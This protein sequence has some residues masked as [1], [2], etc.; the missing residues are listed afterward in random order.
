MSI[1]KLP[2]EI[3][4]QIFTLL[5]KSDQYEC[6][7][8][9]KSCSA[10]A[11]EAFYKKVTLPFHHLGLLK[12]AL[13]QPNVDHLFQHDKWVKRVEFCV[14]DCDDHYPTN[15]EEWFTTNDL[16][17]LFRHLPN[18]KSI[19]YDQ[20]EERCNVLSDFLGSISNIDFHYLAKIEEVS[21]K[22][23]K[24]RCN[25]RH[26]LTHLDVIFT[27][28]V[29]YCFDDDLEDAL[30]SLSHFTRLT[31]LTLLGIQDSNISFIEVLDACPNLIR[32]KYENDADLDEEYTASVSAVVTDKSRKSSQTATVI[33]KHLQILEIEVKKLSIH[34]TNFIAKH[35]HTSRLNRVK[36]LMHCTGFDDW[37]DDSGKDTVLM[38]AQ[39]LNGVANLSLDFHERQSG[40]Y[41]DSTRFFEF[42]D[43]LKNNR[44]MFCGMSYIHHFSDIPHAMTHVSVTINKQMTFSYQITNYKVEDIQHDTST[45]ETTTTARVLAAAQKTILELLI[46]LIPS[47]NSWK[48]F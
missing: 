23:I 29:L 13:N 36:I 27:T 2:H 26:T 44:N 39:S 19:V 48:I 40:S 6:I 30:T 7:L 1:R 28:E 16:Y 34:C 32:L 46:L 12:Q 11:I 8:V 3:Y 9:C 15:Q 24:V 10:A 18:L 25:H 14:D 5:S 37:V 21:C 45:A 33:G 17:K 42:M 35:L 38:L 4:H 41:V 43:T 47:S 22:D 31:H 20:E